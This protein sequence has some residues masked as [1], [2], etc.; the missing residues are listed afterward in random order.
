MR[1]CK[2]KNI[3]LVKHS[4]LKL[5][6]VVAS[7]SVNMWLEVRAKRGAYS[8]NLF[9]N[10]TSSK[11]ERS[12]IARLNLHFSS[13]GLSPEENLMATIRSIYRISGRLPTYNSG[14]NACLFNSSLG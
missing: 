12:S 10:S 7:K 11:L 5:V 4:C 2:S 1:K 8:L 3:N 13:G 6:A 14:I 9:C